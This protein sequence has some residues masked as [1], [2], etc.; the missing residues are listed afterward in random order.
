M[1]REGL[2]SASLQAGRFFY[3]LRV[4]VRVERGRWLVESHRRP[5]RLSGVASY[6]FSRDGREDRWSLSLPSKG[7]TVHIFNPLR[8]NS[9]VRALLDQYG[10]DP[11]V[12]GRA[13][14]VAGGLLIAEGLVGLENPLDGRRGRPGILGGAFLLIF[15]V[16]WLAIT[17]SALSMTQPY[18]DGLSTSGTIT[19]V[20]R[21]TS[22]DADGDRTTTCGVTVSYRVGEESYIA[23]PSYS[24]SGLCS[25]TRGEEIPVSYRP[26]NPAGGRVVTDERWLVV[27]PMVG[28]LCVAVGGVTVLL[29]S[30]SLGFGVWLFLHGRRLAASAPAVPVHELVAEVRSTFL[31]THSPAGAQ[32][33]QPQGDSVEGRLQRL[34]DLRTRGDITEEEYAT[35][36][37]A[38]LAEL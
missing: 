16:I 29:R 38:I 8:R 26:A 25:K 11:Y 30:V 14:Q 15:G 37:A 36:R 1:S 32:P 28:W 33:S 7:A 5:P 22:T 2:K 31:A 20:S 19:Q 12:R 18:K 6:S 24:S 4:W 23:S 17:A 34:T 27:F 10:N 21:T 35:A 3:C 13:E 9:Q